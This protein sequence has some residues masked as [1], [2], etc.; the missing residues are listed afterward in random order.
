MHLKLACCYGSVRGGVAFL[1]ST[2]GLASPQGSVQ[3]SRVQPGRPGRSASTG[4]ADR[5]GDGLTA[6]VWRW[7]PVPPSPTPPRYDTGPARGGRAVTTRPPPA[8][9]VA[10]P[11]RRGRVHRRRR[12]SDT[13]DTGHAPILPAATPL[14]PAAPAVPPIDVAC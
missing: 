11:H 12:F 13:G 1:R 5:E 6:A 2:L 3:V 8:D 10:L 7:A 14:R 4:I 9:V